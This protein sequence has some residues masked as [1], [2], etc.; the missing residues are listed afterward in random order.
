MSLRLVSTPF[1]LRE[2]GFWDMIGLGREYGVGGSSLQERVLGGNELD[3]K[4][5]CGKGFDDLVGLRGV[6][7]T[8]VLN[9]ISL[10]LSKAALK[11]SNV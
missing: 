10:V 1:L 7:A 5:M 6:E 2:W 3:G 11:S 4:G 9:T 8:N